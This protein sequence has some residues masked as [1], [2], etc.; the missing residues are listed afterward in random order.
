MPL[1]AQ[2]N[3]ATIQT[4]VTRDYSADPGA[5]GSTAFELAN[6]RTTVMRTL[7]T[8]VIGLA[9]VGATGCAQ[10]IPE[11]FGVYAV[12]GDRLI[13]LDGN[14]IRGEKVTE[15]KLGRRAGVGAVVN[16]QP[17][18]SSQNTQILEFP[19]DLKIVVY[20]QTGS[21]NVAKSLRLALVPF[22]RNVTIDSGFPSNKKQSAPENA[23]D[24][25]DSPELPG[26]GSRFPDTIAEIL[27]KPM[28]NQKDMVVAGFQEKLSPGLYR[29]NLGRQDAFFGP[30]GGLLFAVQ[31]LLSGETERCVD[32]SVSYNMTMSGTSLKPCGG[33]PSPPTTES[34]PGSAVAADA[35]GN[36]SSDADYDGAIRS[37]YAAS[38]A[39]NW[40]QAL[41][42]FQLASERRKRAGLP[43]V[44][45]G[46]TYLAMGRLEDAW[47]AWDKALELQFPVSIS[48]CSTKG[49]QKCEQGVLKIDPKT[50]A[51]LSEGRTVFET[52]AAELTG[53]NVADHHMQGFVSFGFDAGGK[54]YN[55]NFV[56]V[57]LQ[58]QIATHVNTTRAG[59]AQ[60]TAVGE[61]IVRTIPKLAAGAFVESPR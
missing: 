8:V 57:G 41:V 40:Q 43:W 50:V 20:S 53:I 28:P 1:H 46:N 15:A 49:I 25:G 47:A 55:F 6:R 56:P 17:I 59:M 29:L 4:I 5:C 32:V 19:A 11:Y 21:L 37:G 14:Q 51:F 38:R 9:T 52:P 27:L 45:I 54:K 61:Y 34:R 35:G 44:W 42:H 2:T 10:P 7:I 12:V 13:K 26:M 60:Q 58:P 48:V 18:V 36:V 33:T 3:T 22:V 23:W 39:S 30:S 16:G 31:P 24:L